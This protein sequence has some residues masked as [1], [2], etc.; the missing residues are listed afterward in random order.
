M[1]LRRKLAVL[2]AAASM[3]VMMLLAMAPAAIALGNQSSYQAGTYGKSPFDPPPGAAPGSIR[4]SQ[5]GIL[6]DK[7]QHPSGGSR[8]IEMG[9]VTGP[10]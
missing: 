9:V 1:L 10:R 4:R 5:A 6:H 8:P 2:V 3:A 7:N